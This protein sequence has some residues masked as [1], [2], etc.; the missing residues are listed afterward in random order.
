MI[1]SAYDPVEQEMYWSTNDGIFSAPNNK[2]F[3]ANRRPLIHFVHHFFEN[4]QHGEV[5]FIF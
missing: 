1:S 3:A 5:L 2:N 4:E